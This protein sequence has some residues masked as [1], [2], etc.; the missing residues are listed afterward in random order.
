VGEGFSG[1]GAEDFP[2]TRASRLAPPFV[3]CRVVLFDAYGTLFDL[4]SVEAVCA[5][6]LSLPAADTTAF[7]ALWRAKQLEYSVHRSLLGPERWA[8]FR[9]VT[10]EALD[11][12]LARYG[13]GPDGAAR[14]TLAAAWERPLPYP[15][16][17]AVLAALAPRPR[18][19]L[20]NGAAGMLAAAV[21]AGGL[22][23][24][25]DAV[26]SAD[27]VRVFKPD[28]RVYAL[29]TARF[30]VAPDE[31]CFVSANAWD[32]AGAGA[33]GFRVCWINRLGWPPDRHGPPPVATLSSLS[34][35]PTLLDAARCPS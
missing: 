5:Q 16:A 35:L 29:G 20:S 10:A 32:V 13:L 17:G 34:E 24:H 11:Y 27:A 4:A 18:A 15:E 2:T 6:A 31:V 1:T 19:I 33:F 23:P 14:A 30:G 7:A 3:D 26:L 21:A 8:D 9:Q 28:P 25:L 22:D 12:A